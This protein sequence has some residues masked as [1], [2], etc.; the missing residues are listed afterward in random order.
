MPILSPL[1]PLPY[2]NKNLDGEKIFYSMP[3]ADSIRYGQIYLRPPA[4]TA[5]GSRSEESRCQQFRIAAMGMIA[6]MDKPVQ[7]FLKLQYV[8]RQLPG[9][10]KDLCS[11][12]YWG[13]KL[14]YQCCCLPGWD[15]SLGM[16][17]WKG[18]TD[19]APAGRKRWTWQ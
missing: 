9:D 17:Q 11:K 2:A 8:L 15:P 7:G 19:C 6:T 10:G 1:L 12:N 4:D 3:E 14:R 16:Q 13:K 5:H 18:N